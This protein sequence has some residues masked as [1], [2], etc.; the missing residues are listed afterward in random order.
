MTALKD[1]EGIGEATAKRFAEVGVRSVEALLKAGANAAGRK[2]LADRAGVSADKVLTWVN[3]ADLFRIRGIAGQYSE[4]LEAA[5]VDTVIEL[6]K[7][8]AKNLTDALAKANAAG[9]QRI[10]RAVPSLK[11]VEGWIEQ[12]KKLTRVVSY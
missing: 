5:G 11:R 7:R 1:I 10:V 3:H 6:A 4:L 12:A 9:R 2:D 8:N